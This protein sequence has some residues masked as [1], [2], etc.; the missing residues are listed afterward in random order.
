VT[1]TDR[2]PG[3]PGYRWLYPSVTKLTL[4]YTHHTKQYKI[5]HFR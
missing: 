2:S 5:T 4:S 3:D 1:V